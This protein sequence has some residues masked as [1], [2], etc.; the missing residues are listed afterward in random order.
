MAVSSQ[1][2]DHSRRFSNSLRFNVFA[3]VPVGMREGKPRMV[4]RFV[5]MCSRYLRWKV[6]DEVKAK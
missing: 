3:L 5:Q 2:L 6:K 4:G 1:V